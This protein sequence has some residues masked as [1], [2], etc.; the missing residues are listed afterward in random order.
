MEHRREPRFATDRPVVVS[1]VGCGGRRTARMLSAAPWGI[2]IELDAPAPPGIA[3]TVDFGDSIAAGQVTY[4]RPAGG[5]YY[6]GIRLEQALKSAISL[7][8]LL[9]DGTAFH[10][11][12]ALTP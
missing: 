8:S 5:A 11:G 9:D 3:M 6:I 2:S 7:A 1:L 12:I 4:C 10:D